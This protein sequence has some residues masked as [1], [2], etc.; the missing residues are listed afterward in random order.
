[1]PEFK[2][3]KLSKFGLLELSRQRLQASLDESNSIACPRCAGVGTIRG[4]ESSAFYMYY[5][6]CKKKRLKWSSFIC[7][8]CAVTS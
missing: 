5:A 2:W 7:A 1:M 6:L 4:I 3:V 8:T